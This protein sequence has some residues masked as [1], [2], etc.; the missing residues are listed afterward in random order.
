MQVNTKKLKRLE[1]RA[2]QANA[3]WWDINKRHENALYELN[4]KEAL[5][6]QNLEGNTYGQYGPVKGK[7]MEAEIE[8]R[9]DKSDPEIVPPHLINEMREIGEEREEVARLE[10]ELDTASK[11]YHGLGAC[12]PVLRKFAEQC[13]QA[14][15]L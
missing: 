9:W 6:R 1:E 14:G 4:Q 5:F 8:A 13:G 3:V 2:K 11:R 10:S 12:L 15:G 7:A